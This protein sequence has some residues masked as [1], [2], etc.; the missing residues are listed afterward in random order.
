M[1]QLRTGPCSAVGLLP[2][3][4]RAIIL[5]VSHVQLLVANKVLVFSSQ[6]LL[7]FRC[8]HPSG[9]WL[10]KARLCQSGC[11]FILSQGAVIALVGV[12]DAAGWEVV[13]WGLQYATL[14]SCGGYGWPGAPLM[15]QLFL[16]DTHRHHV[17]TSQWSC[18]R[19]QSGC[20]TTANH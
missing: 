11:G 6:V 1:L 16:P 15:A 9:T 5:Q 2:E 3:F 7:G 20:T 12:L 17:P 8:W 10:C 18:R 13:L 14:I 19:L 4:V